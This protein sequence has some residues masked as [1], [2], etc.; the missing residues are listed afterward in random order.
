MSTINFTS[1]CLLGKQ[2]SFKDLAFERSL[3]ELTLPPDYPTELLSPIKTGLVSGLD[4]YFDM[5]GEVT[6]SILY[7]DN[8]YRFDEIQILSIS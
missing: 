3:A 8:F 7:D 5:S 1:L 4:I 2:V 6:V